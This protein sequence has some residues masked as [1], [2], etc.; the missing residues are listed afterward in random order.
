MNNDGVMDETATG[1]F[2]STPLTSNFSV[3][4]HLNPVANYLTDF[5]STLDYYS[6]SSLAKNDG[7]GNKIKL[8]DSDSVTIVARGN[9]TSFQ[10]STQIKPDAASYN[11]WKSN[12]TSGPALTEVTGGSAI[13]LIASEQIGNGRVFVTGMNA[14]NDKQMGTAGNNQLALNAMNWLAH[15]EPKVTPIQDARG[16]ADGTD[17]VIQGTVT[18]SAF[19]DS[20]Y[21][22]DATGGI[23][24]FSEVPPGSLVNGDIIRVYGK[25][26]TFENNKELEFTTFDKSI[27]KVGT[28]PQLQPKQITTEQA[29][30][31][32]YQGQ[33]VKVIGKV[34]SIPD[35]NSYIIADDSGVEV[36]VYT[37]GYIIN[38]S[39]VAIPKLQVG[40]TL[41]AVGLTG[42]FAE[43]YR[44]RVRDS[45]ELANVDSLVAITGIQLNTDSLNMTV[46]DPSTTLIPTL[47]PANATNKSMTWSSSNMS[48]VTVDNGVV[49][50][51]APGKA[52]VTVETFDGGFKATANA[53]VTGVQPAAPAVTADNVNKVI[54]GI[55]TTM[56]YKVDSGS[57]TLYSPDSPPDLTGEHTVFVRV[58]ATEFAPAGL[59]SVLKFNALAPLLTGFTWSKGAVAGTQTTTIPAGTLK[60]VVG[61]A[62]SQVQPAIGQ[63]ASAYTNELKADTDI[64]AGQSQH[65]F[66][67]S[68]AGEE[69]TG[70]ADVVVTSDMIVAP[71]MLASWDFDLKDDISHVGIDGNLNRKIT[72][73]G[74]SA[75]TSYVAGASGQAISTTGWDATVDKYWTVSVTTANY[76]NILVSSKQY[77][78]NTGPR[79]FK[80]QYSL[81]KTTWMDIPGASVIVKASWPS[82]ATYY[83]LPS[84]ADN[85]QELYIRWLNTSLTSVTGG[86]T[87]SGGTDRIDDIIITGVPIP[88]SPTPVPPAPN[89]TADDVNDVI[90]GIDETMEYRMDNGPWT[91]YDP[92]HLPDLSGDH[93][94]KVRVKA[95]GEV[96][97]GQETTLTFT[98]NVVAPTPPTTPTPPTQP[99]TPTPPTTPTKPTKPEEP[100]VPG[101]VRITSEQLASSIAGKITVVVPSN[102]LEVLIPGIYADKLTGNKLEVKSDK[103][104]VVIPPQLIQGLVGSVSAQDLKDGSISL[105]FEPL[106]NQQAGNI[107]ANVQDSKHTSFKLGGSIYEFSLIYQTASGEK[108]KLSKFNEPITIHLKVDNSMNPELA[109]IYYITDQG[110]LEFVGGEY[111]NGELVAQVNHFSKYAVLE[112]IKTF[113]DVPASH[114]AVHVIQQLAAKQ[115]VNGTRATTFSPNGKVT[116]A[117]FT[118]MLVRALKLKQK[119]S[120]SF[121]DVKDTDWYAEAIAI[122]VQAGIVHGK[123]TMFF[124]PNAVITREE[125]VT[126]MMRAYEVIHGKSPSGHAAAM[127]KDADKISAW[128]VEYVN[129]ASLLQL[130][131]GRSASQFD[132]QGISTRAEAAQI[133]FNLLNSS[134]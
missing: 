123:S 110:T 130:I 113:S 65:I 21:V 127:F 99:T 27:V 118:A 85:Q 122:A 30:S 69:I 64:I 97:A 119:G 94:V 90:L 48:V 36:L 6:G 56:E 11:V 53:T 106:S 111:S 8:T 120:L 3:R 125:M 100:S 134:K 74:A 28:G 54:V 31:E 47:Q 129:E 1:N 17:V 117:E 52:T 37:D 115:I 58:K 24:A 88:A 68:V 61:P 128:A 107:M 60:Y 67:V 82:A 34:K 84:A 55:N 15:L 131:Q 18:T 12:G 71:T 20:A 13:P 9:E 57:W 59:E 25:I 62:G 39:G 126:M 41:M 95:N 112:S 38:Q 49:T 101:V 44:I 23:M 16:L 70:W 19:Y 83:A 92:N 114:W 45:R 10:E 98:T 72:V 2:W 86:A 5:I 4:A 22:Q 51:V 33:L 133:I 103:V 66:I 87:G 43:G 102:T 29:M 81:N 14:F 109:G 124:E 79:D 108:V 63:S 50:P 46:G 132:P 80:L 104:T 91:A 105:K 40:D 75:A 35:E 32:P 93:I 77:G 7:N 116:R 73:V 121:S 42:K 76:S 89:V 26:K 96:P 78:S